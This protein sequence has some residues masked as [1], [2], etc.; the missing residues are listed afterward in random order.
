MTVQ[1]AIEA[2]DDTREYKRAFLVG[3]RLA[4]MYATPI[5]MAD[6]PTLVTDK[7]GLAQIPDHFEAGQEA[8]L[9]WAGLNTDLSGLPGG[10][11]P[12]IESAKTALLESLQNPEQEERAIATNIRTLSKRTLMNVYITNP[13]LAKA[14]L[15]GQQLAEFVFGPTDPAALAERLSAENVRRTCSLLTELKAS[16]PLRAT[17]AVAGSLEYWQHLPEKY[18][19]TGTDVGV[20]LLSQGERWRSLLTGEARADDLLDLG[21]YRQA[22]GEY[23]HQ[24]ALLARKNRWLLG[25]VVTLLALT[26][27]GVFLIIRFAPAGAAVIAGVIAAVAGA[28][29]ITWKTVTV[30]VGKAATLLERPM[31]DDGLSEAVKIA[32]F[33]APAAMPAAEIAELRKQLRK[34]EPNKDGQ[35][36]PA[37]A[38]P[39]SALAASDSSVLA[40]AERDLL[41]VDGDAP[42]RDTRVVDDGKAN[43]ADGSVV[44]QPSPATSA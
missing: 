31:L 22:F 34:A 36:K 2:A 19:G 20:A 24:V 14:L 16:F 26:G 39:P 8:R 44:A 7:G 40:G 32:A 35:P 42:D 18:R 17:A 15:V 21:D 27:S 11:S 38:K 29:G 6:L 5:H 12:E 37:E 25:A 10:T 13:H 3:W 1:A 30:T 4:Q 9:I 23:M 28:L 33:I 43:E 41:D